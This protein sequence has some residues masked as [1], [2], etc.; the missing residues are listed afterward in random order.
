MEGW[1][2][3]C[4]GEHGTREFDG[5]H[6]CNGWIIMEECMNEYLQVKWG[7][8]DSQVACANVGMVW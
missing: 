4:K 2:L 1:C 6:F 7:E 3:D 8:H 5:L